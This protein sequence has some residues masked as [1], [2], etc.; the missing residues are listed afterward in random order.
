MVEDVCP[1]NKSIVDLK[2]VIESGRLSHPK[3]RRIAEE[4]LRL[5][6]DIALGR[7]GEEHIPAIEALAGEMVRQE[8]GQTSAD[9]AGA[10]IDAL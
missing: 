8:F 7:A 10:L 4:I 2:S 9:V 6:E 5:L 1:V 3:S